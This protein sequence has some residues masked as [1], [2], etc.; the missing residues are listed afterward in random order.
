MATKPRFAFRLGWRSVR[1]V[2]PNLTRAEARAVADAAGPSFAAEGI[3]TAKR[4]AAAV[5]QMAEETDGFR[6]FR[7][8]ASGAEYEGRRDLGNVKPGDG[9]RFPGR[10]TIMSTGRANY[11]AASRRFHHDFIAHPSDMQQPKWA[12]KVGAAWWHDNG[13]NQ[14]ADSGDFT[15][16]TRRING[17]VNGLA[18]REAYHR[19]A[20]HVARFLV[21]KRRKP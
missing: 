21:P 7:E 17:G 14:L 3:T 10:G 9:R 15:A 5:A 1:Y 19:R 12:F 20:Q 18:Q 8:Y 16:L 11:A 6:T 2:C 4:A 13:C